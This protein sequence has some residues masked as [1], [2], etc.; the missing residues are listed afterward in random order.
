M[1]YQWID[2]FIWHTQ[3]MVPKTAPRIIP[4]FSHN[5]GPQRIRLDTAKHREQMLVVL[6]HGTLETSLPDVTGGG[7]VAM[8]ALGVRHGKALH[9]AADRRIASRPQE[10]MKVIAH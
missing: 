7:V 6:N 10:Q 4:S 2:E 8:I 9:D 3:P 1:G 5:L